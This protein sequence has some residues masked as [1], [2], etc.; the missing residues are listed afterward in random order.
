MGRDLARTT[1][2]TSISWLTGPAQP[3]EPTPHHRRVAASPP[4][5]SWSPG[6]PSPPDE[7]QLGLS[8]EMKPRP[9]LPGPGLGWEGGMQPE[10]VPAR[11]WAGLVRKL[12]LLWRT[13]V[14]NFLH[15][16]R[17]RRFKICF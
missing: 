10:P 7:G 8:L 12:H 9:A 1:D 17:D 2:T 11:L 4:M 14:S 15:V 16:I 3:A 13:L 6:R 5:G